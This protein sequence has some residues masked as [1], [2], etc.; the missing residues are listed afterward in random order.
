MCQRHCPL[1]QV[2]EAGE[3]RSC[4][5]FALASAIVP[6][7]LRYRADTETECE[8]LGGKH[9]MN[10]ANSKL[11]AAGLLPWVLCAR[12]FADQ[13]QAQPTQDGT[14]PQVLQEIIV[15]ARGWKENKQNVPISETELSGSQIANAGLKN[16]ADAIAMVPNVSIVES[17]S[18]G[19]SFLTVRGLTQV[20]NS[21][22]PVAVVVDGVQ[23]TNPQQFNEEL[24]DIQSI[25]VLRGPQGA[26]YGRNASGGAIL[27]TTRQPENT[28]SGYVDLSHGSGDESAAQ[29]AIGGALIEN[30]LLARVAGSVTSRHGYFQN[31]F[32]HTTA[33]PFHNESFRGTVVWHASDALRFDALFSHLRDHGSAGNFQF[34]GVTLNP[35]CTIASMSFT[36]PVDANRVSRS[37]C[38]YNRGL[39][40]RDID[41][42]SI[43]AT[44]VLPQFTVTAIAAHDRTEDYEAYSQFPYTA[45]INYQPFPGVPYYVN[46]TST[47]Y[48][49]TK[50]S[51]YELR[52][53]SPTDRRLRWL[54]G[55][56]GLITDRF[57][58]TEV[59]RDT[60]TG[61][62]Y[63]TTDPLF[64][65]PVNPT[66]SWLADNNHNVAT[67]AYANLDYDVTSKLEVSLAL[68]YDR[69][70]QRQ[71]VDYRQAL[72]PIPTAVPAGCTADTPADCARYATYAATQPKVSITYRLNGASMIYG[73]VGEGFRSGQFNQNG[74]AAAAAAAG[75]AGVSDEIGKELT[76]SEELGYKANFWSGRVRLDAAAYHTAVS[77]S[78]YF[79]FI[80]AVS[81]QVLVPINKVSIN[82]GE[83]ELRLL[84]VHGLET[85]FGVGVTHSK[86]DS[87]AADPSAVGNW[88]P[89][90]PDHTLNAGVQ[91]TIPLGG[92]LDLML[93][94][95]YTGLGPQYWDVQNDTA[96]HAVNL[97]GLR[98]E[99]DGAVGNGTWSLA[100]S[101]DN[102]TDAVYNAEFVQGGY[103]APAQPRV[104]RVEGRYTF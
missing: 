32:L 98:A 14:G 82:G 1:V 47:Q 64:N 8:Y 23:M 68:R 55:V 93:R 17:Q 21:E 48:F 6:R 42:A 2:S 73:S 87:Y 59:G 33:D 51:S 83:L 58:S 85:Y 88:A 52:L 102:V 75:Q 31:D 74:V 19:T 3:D 44:Y 15:T 36:A 72:A 30:V 104:F 50:G 91:Y 45:S 84:P 94:G 103:V 7:T 18:S 12:G 57:V 71:L 61:I 92:G 86:I 79:V 10:R 67:A 13:G 63:L 5:S 89:Y 22:M 81:A 66:Q 16:M 53:T 49:Y 70:R 40:L 11:W 25:E 46:G 24:Y 78:P 43:K 41:D 69:E 29:G 90:V 76:R 97:L 77:N 28:P 62:A 100:L 99:L 39:G 26:L 101:A 27:I 60:G 96:R 34:Q 37:F 38:A 56:Y 4:P 54:G 20:R 95:D 9:K 80:G 65:A 35:D